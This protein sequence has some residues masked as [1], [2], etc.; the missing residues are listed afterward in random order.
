MNVGE[1]SEILKLETL[2]GAFE[3]RPL[4]G[5]Y[6]SDLLSDVMAHGHDADVLITIQSHKNTVAVATLI[7][8]AAILICNG[9]PVPEE[10]I[11]AARDE[12][13]AIF[14]SREDQFTLSGKIY[15]ILRRT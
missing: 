8:A 1:L 14:R 15:E 6:T 2:Q 12:E 7:G 4:S 5:A 3:D 9:R 13:I 10:M 11:A